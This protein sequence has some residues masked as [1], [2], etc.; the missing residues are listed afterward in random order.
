[1]TEILIETGMNEPAFVPYKTKGQV[2]RIAHNI[3]GRDFVVGDLHGHYNELRHLMDKV[4]F[5]ISVDRLF[6]VGD[7]VDRGPESWECVMLLEQPWFYAV[8]G[9]HERKCLLC[10]WVMVNKSPN[11]WTIDDEKLFMKYKD[12]YEGEWLFK[13]SQ[14]QL[15]KLVPLLAELPLII[16]VGDRQKQ[17]HI[18]HAELDQIEGRDIVDEDLEFWETHPIPEDVVEQCLSNRILFERANHDLKY[19]LRPGLSTTYCGHSPAL[20]R[21]HYASHRFIDSGGCFQKGWFSLIEL[22]TDK[23]VTHRRNT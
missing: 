5:D 6:S 11:Q 2:M 17:W 9:N 10:A 1:M 14:E 19:A 15:N 13:L 8:L 4:Q 7:L 21:L 20:F 23:L 3:H 22:T 12:I 16:S 18:I